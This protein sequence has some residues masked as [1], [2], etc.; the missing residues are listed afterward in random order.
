MNTGHTFSSN[1]SPVTPPKRGKGYRISAWKRT[2]VGVVAAVAVV[3]S[4]LMI[5]AA[6]ISLLEPAQAAQ[7]VLEPAVLV[8]VTPTP[9]GVRT[10]IAATQSSATR[11]LV[12]SALGQVMP[13]P[14]LAPDEV[15]LEL[16]PVPGA[17]GWVR[18][19]DTRINHF[20]DSFLYTGM[21]EGEI[22]HGVAQYDLSRVPRGAPIRRAALVLTG[23]DDTRLDR[24]SSAS[25]Q[26]R[27]LAPVI[28]EQWFRNSF[29]D[30]H[31]AQALQTIL[32]V[33][34]QSNLS[35][36]AT[37]TFLFDA[38]QLALL[39]QTLIDQQP[40]IAFR[41]DGPEVGSDNLFAWDT[42]YGVASA[43]AR[44]ALLIVTGP[45]PAT[46]PATPAKDYVVVT[47]TPTPENVF[48]AVS[49]MLS[50]T[51]QASSTGTPTPTPTNMVTATP[52]AENQATAVALDAPW[53]VTPTPTA[54][55]RTTATMFA[56]FATAQALTTGTWT[57]TPEYFITATATQDGPPTSI[58]HGVITATPRWIVATSTPTPENQATAQ[59][60]RVYATVVALTTGTYTPAPAILTPTPTPTATPLPL[61][62]SLT[63]TPTRTP[64][65]GTIPEVLR[66]KIV[67]RSD[68]LG[69]EQLFVIDPACFFRSGGCTDADASLLSDSYPYE[70]AQEQKA[71]RADGSARLF[72]QLENL[73]EL[74]DGT[75][76]P[77]T[78]VPIVMVEDFTY[79]EVRRLSPFEGGAY[80]PVWSPSGDRVA[81]VSTDPGNDE[82]Y[83]INA[84]GSGLLRLTNNTWE[85]DKHPTW[86][87]DGEYILFYSNRDSGRRQ[88]WIMESDG[89]NQRLLS[90]NQYNDWDPVWIK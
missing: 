76:E 24:N 75:L 14:T 37:N 30:I 28:N 49:I 38:D 45:V 10:S 2:A 59:A 22:F 74:V 5:G 29:Q 20:G 26:V 31:S 60:V 11:Q 19:N 18:S 79:D 85:W 34:D 83:V 7:D 51:A 63:P 90:N 46:P 4:G 23:L 15:L 44:A 21:S 82:I 71:Y 65:P 25:W 77:I 58:P 40:L 39:E 12:A 48:T 88:L 69:G 86:S 36:G 16:T 6:M 80:D 35:P 68:R 89:S 3:V 53:V 50:T 66:G 87:P 64:A 54:A 55:N 9:T 62:R 70:L 1:N 84:D 33:L 72:V 61:L 47:S 56:M 8:S 73:R 67:F 57:P 81:M 52:T 27:W 13:T 78:R 17:I 43:G 41:L 42:G 32:P